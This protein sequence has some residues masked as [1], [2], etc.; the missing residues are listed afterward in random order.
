[1]SFPGANVLDKCANRSSTGCRYTHS[2]A[3]RPG[4]VNRLSTQENVMRLTAKFAEPLLCTKSRL[5]T[6]TQLDKQPIVRNDVS[7][8]FSKYTLLLA[9]DPSRVCRPL[10]ISLE[11]TGSKVLQLNLKFSGF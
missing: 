10:R 1:M 3:C 9:K 4:V 6:C 7:S 5:L 11:S 8:C 2:T